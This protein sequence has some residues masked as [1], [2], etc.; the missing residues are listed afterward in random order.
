MGGADL[1]FEL[2]ETRRPF[3]GAPVQLISDL[4]V[5]FGKGRPDGCRVILTNLLMRSTAWICRASDRSCGFA[6][7]FKK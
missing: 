5:S 6:L 7:L 1:I 2:A 4:P 3:E